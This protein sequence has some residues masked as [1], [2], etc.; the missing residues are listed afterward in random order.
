MMELYRSQHCQRLRKDGPMDAN[1]WLKIYMETEWGFRTRVSD[2]LEEYH[3][4]AW[5]DVEDACDDN[6]HLNYCTEIYS[7]CKEQMKDCQTVWSDR[8]KRV[9]TTA[10][11]KILRKNYPEEAVFAVAFAAWWPLPMDK[12]CCLIDLPETHPEIRPKDVLNYFLCEP[13]ADIPEDLSV[14]EH[15][16]YRGPFYCYESGH[17][18]DGQW[19][20]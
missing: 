7:R 17:P 4:I 18:E 20:D 10:L 1:S 19:I 15:Y 14:C 6:G 9:S 16:R 11:N 12:I 5:Y 2:F 3:Q 13:E 8:A